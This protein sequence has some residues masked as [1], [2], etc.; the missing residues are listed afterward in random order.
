MLQMIDAYRRGLR[1]RG[2]TVESEDWVLAVNKIHDVI[3]F[4]RERY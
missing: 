3:V 2:M 1:K 4:I